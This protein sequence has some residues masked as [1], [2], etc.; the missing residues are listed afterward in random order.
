M[1]FKDKISKI[2]INSINLLNIFYYKNSD[3]EKISLINLKR[4]LNI[5]KNIIFL[6]R[7]RTAIYLLIKYYLI[8]G[9]SNNNVVLT[10][11]Y[12]IPDVINLIK[13][14]GGEPVFVDFEY[15]S[16]SLSIKDL[17]D[18]IIEYNPKILLIT[19][20]HLEDKNLKKII[21]ICKKN[22]MTIL[23]DRAVSYGSIK[24]TNI[25]SEGSIFSFSSFKLLN[26]YFG[27][28]LYCKDD[29]IFEKIKLEV[30]G[31]KKMYLSQYIKQIMLTLSY[32]FL[33]SEIIFRYFGFYLIKL[34]NYNN[35]KNFKKVYLSSG[36]F[37]NS[38][39]T[40]PSNGFYREIYKKFNYIKRCQQHRVKIFS[41]YNKYLNQFAIPK[42]ITK[43]DILNGSC[44]NYLIYNKNANLIRRKLIESNFDTGRILYDNLSKSINYN[45]K[46]I[47]TVNL[48]NLNQGL[49]VL[50]THFYVSQTYAISLAKRILEIVKDTQEK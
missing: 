1:L 41:I 38:Y 36:K 42:K 31:W 49:L 13:K 24:K 6:G 19:H 45:K 15:Q 7:A 44:Y 4:L 14:G 35:K 27:G 46:K 33:T 32:Q 11:A 23:E 5:K 21:D 43:A 29:K 40:R 18:K 16:T 50:P 22:K 10:S 17:K 12:T 47:K 28:A 34:N 2:K 25:T 9:K 26:F 48:N 20:Y 39:F 3:Y 30:L 8:N 37:D